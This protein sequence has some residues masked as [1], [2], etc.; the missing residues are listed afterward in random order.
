MEYDVRIGLEVHCELNTKSKMFC[1]C[2]NS[3]GDEPNTNCCPICTGMPGT[4]PSLN[5]EAVK[6][7]VK[8]GLALN[9][10]INK[11]TFT[12][13]KNYFYPDLPKAYQISQYFTPIC[14]D[15]YLDI[16]VG[17]RLKKIRIKEIHFEE[18]A[19]KLIHD[20]YDDI[21]LIDYNRCGVPLIEIVTMPDIE[22]LA[23]AKEFLKSLKL[24]LQYI[25]VSDCKMEQGS[26]RCDVNVS[27]HPKGSN[28]LGN[29]CEM[30]NINSF[31][32][33]LKAIEYEVQRQKEELEKGNV[34][35]VQTRKWD[36]AKGKSIPLREKESSSDYRFFTEPDI[37]CIVV[38]D[39]TITEIQN[40]IPVLP[41][42][43]MLRYINEY[44]LPYDDALIIVK[45]KKKS[46][47]FEEC[48]KISTYYRE[49]A[50][51]IINDFVDIPAFEFCRVLELVNQGKLSNTSVKKVFEEI[52]LKKVSA[53]FALESLG[54]CQINDEKY[55]I[56]IIKKVLKENK[57]A[58]EDY[59][60]GK[61]NAT[62][63]LIGQCIKKSLG[64]ANPE[65]VKNLI[66]EI[67]DKDDKDVN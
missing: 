3:F 20:A 21:T 9:C 47:F 35:K 34:I 17:G 23:Q 57:K 39:S 52:K 56:D 18:D 1:S 62:G 61:K 42:E 12:D 26:L 37:P 46:D 14:Q 48:A 43:R 19:G 50:N 44:N 30:K 5:K 58:F 10:T 11:E 22:N 53:D 31:S 29:R 24:L 8:A 66:A 45:D 16:F 59:K 55:I 49:T 33:A 36:S 32:A 41:F 40:E 51:K 65:K 54:L 28:V 7:A 27:I 60:N 63:F 25:D 13:R 15:G 67:I 4:L 38:D 6:K 64:K 2:K